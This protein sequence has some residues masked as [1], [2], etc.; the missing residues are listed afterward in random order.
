MGRK[1]GV[2]GSDSSWEEEYATAGPFTS[3]FGNPIARVLDQSMIVGKMEQTISM[4]AESTNQSY[5]TVEKAIR[6]LEGMGLL[7]F[8]RKIGNARAYRFEVE[9]HLSELIEVA[10]KIQLSRT[11]E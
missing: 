1:M 9:N 6:R 3:I 2:G 7:S 4:L 10:Q 5:K 11:M 8:S